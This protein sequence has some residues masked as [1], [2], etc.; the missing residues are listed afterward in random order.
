MIHGDLLWDTGLVKPLLYQPGEIL[1]PVDPRR[2]MDTEAMKAEIRGDR[3]LH[4]SKELPV[5]R[6]A[7]ESMG[8]FLLRRH[9]RFR[10][11]SAGLLDTPE[12]SID[13]GLNLA[14]AGMDIRV[15]CLSGEDWEEVDTPEDLERAEVIFGGR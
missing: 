12:A 7:G 9:R 10:E 5:S 1:L 6:S 14:A 2:R 11:V 3:L 15:R 13:N 8:V 4:L